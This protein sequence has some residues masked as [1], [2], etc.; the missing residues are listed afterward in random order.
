MPTKSPGPL[1]SPINACLSIKSRKLSIK[2]VPTRS[3]FACNCSSA[4][5]SST[6][7]PIAHETGLPPNVLKYSMPLWNEAAIPGVVTTAASGCPLPMGLP[8]VTMSGTTPCVSNP[9]KCVHLALALLDNFFDMVRVFLG[10]PRVGSLVSAAIDIR[11]RHCVYIRGC[12]C[13]ARPIELVGTNLDEAGCVAVIRGIDYDHVF[14]PGVCT[15]KPQRQFICLAAGAHKET[16]AQRCWQKRAQALGVAHKVLVQ[17]T[18]VG[19]EYR[20]LFLCCLDHARMA[21][22]NV[23]N[24][25]NRVQVGASVL[26]VQVLHPAAYNVER[27][28][29]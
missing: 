8:I 1:I 26:V 22:T 19:V 10:C 11:H 15:R 29:V 24:V 6:A 18:R 9:Q 4:I 17:V 3:A 2:C 27:L 5:T 13:A 16:H 14:L 12:A 21:M 28:L 7:N 23:S 20:H 25:V